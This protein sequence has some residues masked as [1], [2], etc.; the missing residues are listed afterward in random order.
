MPRMDGYETT[1]QIRAAGF[2][3]LPIIAVTAHALED[4][5]KLCMAAGM[6]GY[7]SKPFGLDELIRF[8]KQFPHTAENP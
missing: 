2:K 8:I 1:R 6:N 3:H 5:R 7:L 4:T